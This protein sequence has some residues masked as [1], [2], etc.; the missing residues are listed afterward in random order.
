MLHPG[1]D[2]IASFMED[3]TEARLEDR[4]HGKRM[5]TLKRITRRLW[6]VEDADQ[7][8]HPT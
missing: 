7:E 8:H 2:E 3:V 4:R 5:G 1:Q 6:L